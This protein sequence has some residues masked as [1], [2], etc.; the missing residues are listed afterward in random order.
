MERLARCPLINSRADNLA[1]VNIDFKHAHIVQKN[2]VQRTTLNDRIAGYGGIIGMAI[3][4]YVILGNWF[5]M[6]EKPGGGPFFLYL[7]FLKLD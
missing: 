2:V 6:K 7:L 1:L 3:K 4:Y 5:H